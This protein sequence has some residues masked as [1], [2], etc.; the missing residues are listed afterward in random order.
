MFKRLTVTC[1]ISIALL[2]IGAGDARYWRIQALQDSTPRSAVSSSMNRVAEAYVKLVLALGQHDL[3]Y[4][5]AYYGPEAWQAKA[6]EEKKSLEA[7]KQSAQPLLAELKKVEVSRQEEILQL[8]HQYMVKQLQSLVARAEMLQGV[9]LTFD[10]ES[11]ALYD[12]VAPT[13]PESHFKEVI[14]RIDRLV[15]AGE[16]SLVARLE[17]YQ[18]DFI[19]PRDKLDAA[20]AAAIEEARRRTKHHIILPAEESFVVEYVTN[21][22]WSAY[23]WY[24]GNSR[25]VI[26]IN[27]D[28]PTYVGRVV[29]LACHEGYPGHHVYNALLEKH[30]VKER[31]WMEFSVYALFSPQSLV[32][33]GSAEYGVEV[34]FPDQER[35]VFEREVLFPLAGLDPAKA[36]AYQALRKLLSELSYATNEAARHYLDGK[37]GADKA[38]D[39]LVT[40]ALAPIERARKRV[41]FI[42][43]NRSYVINYNLGQ[44]LVKKY[45]ERQGGTP[46]Q[47]KKRWEEFSKLLS[48]P[49]LPSG[50]E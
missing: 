36:E 45:I 3:S 18:R 40:Y 33:E 5:D 47:P 48:S 10:E 31:G 46:D 38:A 35:I 37:V 12:A 16:G 6:R 26:Q 17:R 49:R 44:D 19:V 13:Y 30:L 27:T 22:P 25:S 39:W 23:N 20:F 42:D 24:K 7:I 4:V 43:Q 41:S 8:R 29:D 1:G 11:R 15:P 2:F 50:L 32:A 34:A 14:S 21:K 28:L 9:K